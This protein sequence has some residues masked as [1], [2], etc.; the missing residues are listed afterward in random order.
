MPHFIYSYGR[1]RLDLFSSSFPSRCSASR[2]GPCGQQHKHRYWQLPLKITLLFFSRTYA[3]FLSQVMHYCLHGPR[4][5]LLPTPP[6]RCSQLS[7]VSDG[8]R[9]Q[10]MLDCVTL[11]ARLRPGV[12]DLRLS[13]GD[14]S[15]T[16][17][18][19][20]L[21]E[22]GIESHLHQSLSDIVVW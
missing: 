16:A 17:A 12:S 6:A 5:L 3:A 2:P 14:S 13:A 11:V 22:G 8:R 20:Q 7:R 10:S 1:G 9:R 18:S 21:S 4:C 15:A 19:L